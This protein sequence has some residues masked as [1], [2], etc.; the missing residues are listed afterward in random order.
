MRTLLFSCVVIGSAIAATGCSSVGGALG[1]S[2]PVF[3]LTP[4]TEALRNAHTQASAIPKELEKTLL[5]TYIVEPG[6]TLLIQ[7]ADLDSS[8]RVPGDQ[9]VLQDGTIDLGRFGRPVV[10]GKTLPEIEVEVKAVVLARLKDVDRELA[11]VVRKD[12]TKVPALTVRIVGRASKIYYVLG[13][14]NA[15]GSYPLTGRETVLDG[16]I[17]AGN[18]TRNASR[19]N[20]VLARLTT[21][22]GCRTV[23]PVCLTEIEQQADP[24]TNYQLQPGDRIYVASKSYS[25]GLLGFG[26]KRKKKYCG[27]CNHPKVACPTSVGG[28]MPT[29]STGTVVTTVGVPV[30]PVPAMILDSTP[31][32]VEPVKPEPTPE[33]NRIP[34]AVNGVTLPEVPKIPD[35]LKLPDRFP[36]TGNGK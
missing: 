31:M 8:I 23:L 12:P 4:E 20:V 7:P 33:P 22:N 24:T 27:P 10:A 6:D 14:V 19:G 21:V 17:A 30:S 34:R 28:S 15:P 11:E 13:E 1:V 2:A 29:G 16:V 25:E 18:L 3:A 26:L 32:P 5:P 9:I 36:A 35:N